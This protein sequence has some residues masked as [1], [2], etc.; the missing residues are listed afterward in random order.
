MATDVCVLKAALDQLDKIKSK[1][2]LKKARKA[3][4]TLYFF[5]TCK[6]FTCTVQELQALL[7][8]LDE[9]I[10][11]ETKPWWYVL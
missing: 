10:A 6:V 2:A 1:R 5:K 4:A 8:L 9:R 7:E 3:I 11:A